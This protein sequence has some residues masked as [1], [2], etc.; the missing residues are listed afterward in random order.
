MSEE[1]N[2]NNSNVET[3]DV[4]LSEPFKTSVFDF[5]K[6]AN[7]LTL[8]IKANETLKLNVITNT[9]IIF[10]YS[11]PKVGSTSIVSSLRIF[12]SDKFNIIHIHDEEMLKIL[13][14]IEGISIN[15]IILYNAYLGKDIYVIDVYR[16]PIE[17]KISTFFE[18]IGSYHF[19]NTE[20]NINSYNINK[21]INRFN[22]IFPYIGLG[23]HFM[24][25]YNI[26]IPINFD[27]DNKYLLVKENGISYIKLRLNDSNIWG[28]LLTSIFGTTICIV[29][30]YESSSKPIK[31]LYNSFK[32]N[33]RIPK[34]LLDGILNC[35]YFNYYYSQEEKTQY[36]NE[37]LIKSTDSIIEYTPE[38]YKLYEEITIENSYIDYV[39]QNHYID[40]GCLCK[41]CNIKRNI[42]VSKIINGIQ[43][44]D[45]VIHTEAKTELINNRVYQVTNINRILQNIPKKTKGKNFNKQM[46]NIVSGQRF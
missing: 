16:S 42:L 46:K 40:E 3:N 27:T 43:I 45:R 7:K 24:D 17:R 30:D 12:G 11:E 29:K 2:V 13:G 34:N 9:K 5:I 4:Y 36:Y 37:W 44:N 31:D 20:E 41:A 14:H 32:N 21:V 8:L 23:D 19:N 25:R 6:D 18:K 38:Q 15:E 26:Q 28:Q 10:V 22:N 39:Q 33:Y 35:K 1:N